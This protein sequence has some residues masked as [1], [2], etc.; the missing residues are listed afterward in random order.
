MTVDSFFRSQL[1]TPDQLNDL[2]VW[3]LTPVNYFFGQRLVEIVNAAVIER[4]PLRY[5]YTEETWKMTAVMVA[6]FI[7]SLILGTI[8]R[9]LSVCSSSQIR[10]S[11]A[12]PTQEDES[13][14][15]RSS[16]DSPPG[17]A[18][19]N[20]GWITPR[21]DAEESSEGDERPAFMTPSPSARQQ[22]PMTRL[23]QQ[24]DMEAFY[25]SWKGFR[26]DVPAEVFEKASRFFTDLLA[27]PDSD[28]DVTVWL[29][30]Q[31]A[32]EGYDGYFYAS[33]V[34][35]HL[36]VENTHLEQLYTAVIEKL[37]DLKL[38]MYLYE[39]LE[40]FVKN[41]RESDPASANE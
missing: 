27:Q 33:F 40:Q 23:E 2:A 24:F 39:G 38:E 7:P 10:A 30:E 18:V 37:F 20:H 31:L 22:A 15:V 8:V 28:M 36:D 16:E 6:L 17:R 11:L 29:D 5:R 4:A 25:E 26:L 19:P 35:Y 9:S 12:I 21:S 32:S 34:T 14:E 41:N 1:R 3:T 13:S